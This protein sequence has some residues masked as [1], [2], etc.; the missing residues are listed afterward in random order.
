MSLRHISLLTFFTAGTIL[1]T[2]LVYLTLSR[3]VLY[4]AHKTPESAPKQVPQLDKLA[5]DRKMLALAHV[6]T[7]T[8]SKLVLAPT[9]GDRTLSSFTES[10]L[11]SSTIRQW[12][13]R[14]TYPNAGALLP[15]N[16]IVAYYGNFYS[17]G[18]GI[19]GEADASSTLAKL[20][21]AAAEWSEADPSTPVIHAID[22]IAVAAQDRPGKDGKYR[23]QMPDNQ[24]DKAL[25]MARQVNGIVILE[26]QI[27]FST[28]QRDLPSLEKY[29]SMPQVHLALDPEFSMKHKGAPGDE[30]GTFSSADINYAAQYLQG[31]VQK[32]NLPPKILIVHRFTEEMVTGYRNIKPLPE[33]QIVMDMDGWG[34]GARKVG[35]YERVIMDEPV[36]FTGF[37]IFYKNDMKP[38]STR[39]M[40][41]KEVLELT[42]APSF[43]QYQ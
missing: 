22:Y 10:S 7:T 8:I 29:L 9:P 37:K 43:I 14:S 18:M 12:P 41:P 16:R 39:L 2:A 21:K 42:P 11:A 33:V 17:K 35:T 24:I 4:C 1:L 34:Y 20:Q 13:T 36:Q 3:Q 31:L 27:G 19:L 26:M 6:S 30:I 5:Y 28:L 38:P 15:F 23:I 32:H 25:E 40:T